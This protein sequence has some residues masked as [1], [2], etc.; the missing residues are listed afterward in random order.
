M[1][2]SFFILNGEKEIRFFKN[3]QVEFFSNK[4]DS[5]YERILKTNKNNNHNFFNFERKKIVFKKYSNLFFVIVCDEE[6]S[7]LS[8]L[9]LI[10]LF[11]ECLDVVY[12]N[13]RE[14]DLMLQ[15][16]KCGYLLDFI[17]SNG[18][19]IQ[20]NKLQILQEYNKIYKNDSL[21]DKSWKNLKKISFFKSLNNY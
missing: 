14:I 1:I 4:I 18:T 16:E 11:L 6:E 21:L 10:H 20:T 13:V 17:I 5:I 2:F 3:Y 15:P 7:I 12:E 8:L 19:V 9:D